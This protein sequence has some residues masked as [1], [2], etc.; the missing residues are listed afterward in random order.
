MALRWSKAKFNEIIWSKRKPI[1]MAV[2]AHDGIEGEEEM[3]GG[4]AIEKMDSSMRM[5][6]QS[7]LEKPKRKWIRK[8]YGINN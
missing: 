4:K 5:E 7:Q 8:K 2:E 3:T 6:R 1:E